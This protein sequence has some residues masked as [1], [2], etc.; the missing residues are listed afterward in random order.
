MPFTRGS[1]QP[2]SPRQG[3]RTDTVSTNSDCFT[4]M[5]WIIERLCYRTFVISATELVVGLFFEGP[6]LTISPQSFPINR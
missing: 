5:P 3:L 2:P 6:Q 1:E 4:S